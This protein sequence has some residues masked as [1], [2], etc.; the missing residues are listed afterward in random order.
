MTTIIVIATVA[1][2]VLVV[3]GFRFSN[4]S[5]RGTST[6]TDTSDSDSARFYATTD[7]PAGPDAEDSPIP[8][9]TEPNGPAN[10]A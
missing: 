8:H 6:R 2:V 3:A 9:V 4:N 7:R 1:I 10:S 5:F